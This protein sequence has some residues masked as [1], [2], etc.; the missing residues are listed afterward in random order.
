MKDTLRKE[1]IKRRL[2][3]SDEERFEREGMINEKL[4]TLGIF[5]NVE[6]VAVYMPVRGE[7]NILPFAEYMKKQGKQIFL[8]K[9]VGK[10]LLFG[11]YTKD[12]TE[13]MYGILEPVEAEV[14]P[15]EIEAFV[16]PGVAFDFDCNRLGYGGGYFDGIMARRKPYQCFV[17]VGFSFQVVDILPT[18]EWD[19]KVDLLVTDSHLI[20]S[21]TKSLIGGV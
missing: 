21:S 1:M 19:E 12:L 9:V 2:S 13:G 15:S 20:V 3:L 17:G 11:R 4:K 18:D 8:P 6:T 14:L 5:E 10:K 7:V 16:V